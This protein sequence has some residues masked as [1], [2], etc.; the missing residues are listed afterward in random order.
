M[1]LDNQHKLLYYITVEICT[2]A[3][4]AIRIPSWY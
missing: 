3:K 1:N 2:H 4:F